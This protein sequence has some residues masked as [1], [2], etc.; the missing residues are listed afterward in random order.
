MHTIPDHLLKLAG[1]NKSFVSGKVFKFR[2][3]GLKYD[4]ALQRMHIPASKNVCSSDIIFDPKNNEQIQIELIK[5]R[6]P[7]APDAHK[8]THTILQQILFLKPENGLKVLSGNDKSKKDQYEYLFMCNYN[9]ANQDKP[10]HIRPSSGYIFEYLD[11]E[12]KAEVDNRKSKLKHGAV[13]MIYNMSLPERAILSAQ[14][15]K[16]KGSGF[17]Y[18]ENSEEMLIEKNLIAFAE[19][20]PDVII[21]GDF[22]TRTRLI[23]IVKQAEETNIIKID[24]AKK[25]VVWAES[26]EAFVIIP[27]GKD[28]YELLVD[29]FLSDEGNSVLKTIGTAL[30]VRTTESV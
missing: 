15:A 3:L 5:A 1:I 23:S 22:E 14:L 10:W 21:K 24:T 18:S 25:Q 29:F 27:Q 2:L 11:D 12:I 17:N 7:T 28:P 8:E 19:K 9:R 4:R 26:N 30:K 16:K 6:A 20:Y 13:S